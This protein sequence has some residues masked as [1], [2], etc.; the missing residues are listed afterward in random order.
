MGPTSGAED[1][2]TSSRRD[3]NTVL[4]ALNWPCSPM[5]REH[6]QALL[7]ASVAADYSDAAPLS[8]P[9][10]M[11]RPVKASTRCRRLSPLIPA[12]MERRPQ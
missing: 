11:N 12:E 2:E 5:D 1:S 8:R 10:P 3:L 9:P 7:S 4:E 6:G